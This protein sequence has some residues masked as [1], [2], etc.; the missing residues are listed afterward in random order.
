MSVSLAEALDN[1][2]TQ[3]GTIDKQFASKFSEFRNEVGA[4]DKKMTADKDV[5]NSARKQDTPAGAVGGN[6]FGRQYQRQVGGRLGATHNENE[7][8]YSSGVSR[9]V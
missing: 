1:L 7:F 3:L 4:L 8:A 5:F 6:Y 9:Y 2:G